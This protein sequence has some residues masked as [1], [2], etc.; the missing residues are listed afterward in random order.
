MLLW[1]TSFV[2]TGYLATE[3][4]A[5]TLY[6]NLLL[7]SV[8]GTAIFGPVVVKFADKWHPGWTIGISF[9][10]RSVLLVFGF[11]CLQV[12]DT[13]W[14]YLITFLL[15]SCTGLQAVSVETY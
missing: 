8:G 13:F 7:T 3:E 2:D 1:V 4:D 15:M 14:A 11:P 9:A 10:I 6:Q 12:P 5:K